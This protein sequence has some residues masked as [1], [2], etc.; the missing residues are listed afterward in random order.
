[1]RVWEAA[2]AVP[3]RALPQKAT[4]KAMTFSPDGRLLATGGDPLSISG[5]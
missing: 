2:Q 4:V 1:V 3:S 5:R